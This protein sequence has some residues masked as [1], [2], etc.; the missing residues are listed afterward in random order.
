MPNPIDSFQ[1]GLT[2]QGGFPE[3]MPGASDFSGWA[4]DV[5]FAIKTSPSQEVFCLSAKFGINSNGYN[6]YHFSRLHGYLFFGGASMD[7]ITNARN[8]FTWGLQAGPEFYEDT[9]LQA[10]NF[11]SAEA[12]F[13]FESYNSFQNIESFKLAV[14]SYPSD[15]CYEDLGSWFLVLFAEFTYCFV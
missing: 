9:P 6:A 11:F 13:T 10:L 4:V 5:F 1:A 2:I 12:A 14:C 15:V 7:A 3:G 8:G